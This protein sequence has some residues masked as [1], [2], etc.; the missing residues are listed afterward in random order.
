MSSQDCC[1]AFIPTLLSS[2][3]S[4]ELFGPPSFPMSVR[5]RLCTFPTM[6]NSPRLVIEHIASPASGS[7]KWL[8]NVPAASESFGTRQWPLRTRWKVF[9]V[10][11]LDLRQAVH[12]LYTQILVHTVLYPCINAIACWN[13][14]PRKSPA[15][16]HCTR[17]KMQRLEELLLV[18]SESVPQ[19]LVQFDH[20]AN[21]AILD[22][23][24]TPGN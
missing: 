16:W 3:S 7:V 17:H 1:A 8:A 18:S 22:M 10:C 2:A 15:P 24:F 9:K 6:S 23:C 5:N 13:D 20:S 21:E 12:D 14:A 19:L 4:P 11:S